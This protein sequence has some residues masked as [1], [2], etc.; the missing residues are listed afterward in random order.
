[1]NKRAYVPGA[2]LAGVAVLLAVAWAFLGAPGL[3]EAQAKCEGSEP[4]Q[5]YDV[6]FVTTVK[7]EDGEQEIKNEIR[8]NGNMSHTLWSM[9][10][11]GTLMQGE[12]I[13][14]GSATVYSRIPNTE[15]FHLRHPESTV[16]HDVGSQ[17]FPQGRDHLCVD[18]DGM[19]A[20]FV[21]TDDIGK[22]YTIKETRGFETLWVNDDGWLV[23][24]EDQEKVF[25]GTTVV[26][27]SGIGEKNEIAIPDTDS[28]V[29]W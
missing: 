23:Q 27:I 21:E 29:D 2:S 14:D 28:V 13:Y 15:A 6:L 8:I 25:S 19:E 4:P 18:L 7:K 16:I 1:M 10:V 20:D 11:Q 5:S 12:D 24:A 3:T 9:E 22:K 26:T 17:A